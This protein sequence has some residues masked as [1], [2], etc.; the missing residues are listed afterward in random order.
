MGVAV[1]FQF[2][3]DFW[4]FHSHKY[5][6]KYFTIYIEHYERLNIGCFNIYK[7]LGVTLTSDFLRECT[8][9]SL[10][11]RSIDR[12]V[13]DRGASDRGTATIVYLR[14]G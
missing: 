10:R 2:T 3:W 9:R 1:S 6:L 11:R 5:N 12:S 7:I 4:K 13:G 8:I 14:G